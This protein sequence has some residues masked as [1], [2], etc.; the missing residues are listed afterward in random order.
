MILIWEL[1]SVR[2]VPFAAPY[3]VNLSVGF[4]ESS[5]SKSVHQRPRSAQLRHPGIADTDENLVV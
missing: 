1:V 3:E 4:G 5:P 2:S